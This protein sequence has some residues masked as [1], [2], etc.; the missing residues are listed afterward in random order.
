MVGAGPAGLYT[1]DELLRHPGVTVDVLD[2]LREPHGLVRYGVAPDHPHTRRVQRLFGQIERQPGFRYRLGVEVGRDVTLGRLQ[3][4]Y[5]AVVYA[6]GAASDRRLGVAGEDLPGSLAATDLVAW[7]NGHPERRDLAVDLAHER[8]VVVGAGNVGLDVARMLTH[9]PGVLAGTDI[10]PAAL[11]V[12]AASRLREV[13]VLGRRAAADAAFTLPELLGLAGLVDDG[14][15]DAPSTPA[16]LRSW[17][18]APRST[19]SASSP[20]GH[21]GP[22]CG[23]WCCGSTPG[24]SG[25]WAPTA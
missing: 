17:V 12:L 6:V 5:D 25:S 11:A 8:V 23:G 13:V 10:D 15:L 19:C 14:R 3:E 16:V 22:R 20:R 24:R 18:A 7:Y 21:R 2:R 4:Q 1:A 9:D